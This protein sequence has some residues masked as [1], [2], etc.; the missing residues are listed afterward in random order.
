MQHKKY[1]VLS[2]LIIAALPLSACGESS[3]TPAEEKSGPATVEKID[4][5][6]LVRVTLTSKAAK[7]LGIET[8]R[9]RNGAGGGRTVIPYSAVVYGTDGETSTYANPE[10][11][12]FV[13]R[14]IKVDYIEGSRAVLSAGPASGTTVATVG[15]AELLGA[16]TEFDGGG[17]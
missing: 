16:E 12:T 10:G 17:H 8:T 2:L 7:R 1:W 6:Q 14:D 9:V 11:L 13:R 3:S 15:V 4:G 5:T